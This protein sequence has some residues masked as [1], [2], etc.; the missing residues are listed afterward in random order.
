MNSPFKYLT[1]FFRANCKT[2]L[3]KNP[4]E[5]VTKQIKS[6]TGWAGLW[7]SDGI[8]LQYYRADDK[9]LIHA[10][11]FPWSKWPSRLY[12][13]IKE[14]TGN[15]MIE[16]KIKASYSSLI[17]LIVFTSVGL[18]YI[19]N[20]IKESDY[21]KLILGVITISVLPALIIWYKKYSDTVINKRFVDYLSK[22]FKIDEL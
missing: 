12:G 18:L 5:E 21:G 1:T 4:P 2:Y 22:S 8:E 20:S 9:F 11:I 16:V 15:T 13:T 7:S 3:I 14:C 19:M 17:G 6:I 10:Y